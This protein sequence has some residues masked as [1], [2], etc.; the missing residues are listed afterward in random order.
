MHC[1]GCQHLGSQ[2]GI[3]PV[4]LPHGR[5]GRGR[6]ELRLRGARPSRRCSPARRFGGG[7]LSV[8]LDGEPVVDVWTGWSDRRGN[9]AL[10]RRHRR[11]GVLRDQGHG[12]DR[13]PPT[14]RP[15]PDRLRRAGRRVLARVR[16][17]RQGRR[18]PS[19]TCMRHRAGLSQLNGVSKADLLDHRQMEE[20]LAAAPVNR[21]LYG[22]PAYHALTYGWLMSGLARAVTGKGMRELIRDEVAEP[23][24]TDGLHLGRPPVERADAGRADHRPAGHVC[25]TRCSTSWRPGSAALPCSGGLRLDVLPR[26]ESRCAGRYSVPRQRDPRGQRRG[27]RAGP[28]PDVRRDRQRRRASTA[29]SSSRAS[30]WPA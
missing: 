14:R 1:D 27:H 29:R 20:R 23:L 9:R 18:S 19:A 15:R 17:Q 26:H 6:P 25:R 24:N 28:G 5:S 2:R 22:K 30:W 12:L 13:H 21:L 8:Y 10:D 4:A 3:D 11:D 16:R 7:A